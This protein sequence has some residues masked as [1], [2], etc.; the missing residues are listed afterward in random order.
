MDAGHENKAKMEMFQ[1]IKPVIYGRL[2]ITYMY[3]PKYSHTKPMLF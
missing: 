3:I 2:V 1:N